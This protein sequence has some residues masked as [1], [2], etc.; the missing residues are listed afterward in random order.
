VASFKL[1]E[2]KYTSVVRVYDADETW[3]LSQPERFVVKQMVLAT[4][5][6]EEDA[7]ASSI[8]DMASLA[9]S[10]S[11]MTASDSIIA[12]LEGEQQQQQQAQAAQLR[13]SGLASSYPQAS[14]P[15][16][17]R[18][19]ASSAASAHAVFCS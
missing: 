16:S 7:V 14:S 12:K 4:C 3:S 2:G 15:G 18:L 8:N 13:R 9:Q 11:L 1:P 6:T 5:Q 19:L 17:R 10:A